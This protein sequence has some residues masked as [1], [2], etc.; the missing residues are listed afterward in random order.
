[1][2][3]KLFYHYAVALRKEGKR[4]ISR[5]AE[6]SP[7]RG[8]ALLYLARCSQELAGNGLKKQKTKNF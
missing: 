4:K 7:D 6:I 3:Y 1:M 5:F 8:D 2:L